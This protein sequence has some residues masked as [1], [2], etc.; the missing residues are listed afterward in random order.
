MIALVFLKAKL[1]ERKPLDVARDGWRE[2]TRAAY[3]AVGLHWLANYLKG[4]FEPGAAEKYRYRFRSRYYRMRKDR[5]AAAHRPFSRGGS[6]VIAGGDRPNVLTGYMMHEML[7]NQVV[8]GFPSRCTV[9]MYGLAYLTTRFHKKAQPDKP[10]E[11][12]TVTDAERK[13][14]GKV[15]EK[16][17]ADGIEAYRKRKTIVTE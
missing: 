9:I 3:R 17:L 2:I 4:H 10:K 6:P 13:E 11:I 12:T 5:L 15:L 14:L 1:T 7:R 16:A 8:R